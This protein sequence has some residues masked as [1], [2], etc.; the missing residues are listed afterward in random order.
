MSTAGRLCFLNG[1]SWGW[2]YLCTFTTDGARDIKVRCSHMPFRAGLLLMT[3]RH[4][5]YS[6]CACQVHDLGSVFFSLTSLLTVTTFDDSWLLLLTAFGSLCHCLYKLLCSKTYWNIWLCDV[7]FH[8][9]H[10]GLFLC[11]SLLLLCF[12]DFSFL[13]WKFKSLNNFNPLLMGVLNTN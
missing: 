6:S 8:V 5:T 3:I 11:E 4:S 1:Y 9:L 13:W 10:L 7:Y 12:D 2:Q